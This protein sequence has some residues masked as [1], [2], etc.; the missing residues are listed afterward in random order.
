VTV[1]LLIAGGLVVLVA[2]GELLVRGAVSIAQSLGVS[3]LMIGLTLVGFGTSTPELVTSIDAAL[4][5]APGVAVGN[6]IGSNICN[7]LLILGLAALIR[8]VHATPAAFYRDG[9]VLA[10]ATALGVGAA[11][12]GEIGRLAG[13]AFVTILVGYIV[14]AYLLERAGVDPEAA[15]VH[16]AEAET[17]PAGPRAVTRAALFLVGGLLMTLLGARW[18]VDGAVTA[19]QAFGISDAIIGLT[20]VA[21]GT[22]LP[23]LVA[24]VTAARR[25]QSDVAFGNIVGSNIYN[26]V[27][28]LGITALVKPIPVE[29]QFAAVDVWVMVA[30]TLGLLVFTMSGWRI[31]RFEGAAMLA[32]YAVYVGWL[33]RQAFGA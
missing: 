18:L 8:P 15:A 20:I 6:V 5:D 4:A 29:A 27:G 11:L 24:S 30:A 9:A 33:A 19:A 10:V 12:E 2:G 22:S 3:P 16:A 32:A 28:I 23:E 21:V 26:I 13:A 1:I 14:L 25:G 31:N 17:L 7:I